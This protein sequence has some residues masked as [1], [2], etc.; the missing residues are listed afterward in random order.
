MEHLGKQFADLLGRA[1]DVFDIDYGED[2][3]MVRVGKLHLPVSRGTLNLSSGSVRPGISGQTLGLMLPSEA[4]EKHLTLDPTTGWAMA[5]SFGKGRGSA[6]SN[7]DYAPGDLS[8]IVAGVLDQEDE[9]VWDW[10]HRAVRR[11]AKDTDNGRY[12]IGLEGAGKIPGWR[13]DPRSGQVVGPA[14]EWDD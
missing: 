13:F 6:M 7:T 9:G 11:D 4:G 1:N 2:P 5:Q 14:P 3:R 8:G 10:Q 12:I